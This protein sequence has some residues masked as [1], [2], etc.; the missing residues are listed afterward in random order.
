[1]NRAHIPGFPNRIPRLDWQTYLPKFK[2]QRGD[3]VALH[4]IKFHMHV[5]KLG[6]KLHEDSLMKMFMVSLE[7]KA[8]AWYEM[9]PPAILYSLEDFH[10][11]FYKHYRESYSFLPFVENCCENFQS[12]ILHLESLY[13]D[14]EVMDEE[15]REAWCE[16]PFHH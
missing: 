13:G 8:R 11:V 14:E 3:D 1:M 9:L 5:H 15:I 10:A 6:V 4:L 7:G 12:F 2:D 16:T